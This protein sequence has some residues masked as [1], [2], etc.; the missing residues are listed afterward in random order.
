MGRPKKPIDPDQVKNLA[1]RG[2]SGRQIA[3]HFGVNEATIRR[4]FDALIAEARQ[5]GAAKLLDV[6]WQRGVTGKSDRVL[7]HLADRIIGKIPTVIKLSREQLIEQLEDDA[8]ERGL[9]P[10][11]AGNIAGPENPDDI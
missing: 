5:H 10:A 1:E 4:K 6:L 8:K 9:G 2:W 11:P 3:A 7:V